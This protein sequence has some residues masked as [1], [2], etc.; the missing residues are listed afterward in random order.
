MGIDSEVRVNLPNTKAT[1]IRRDELEAS[2]DYLSV[3]YGMKQLMVDQRD[4]AHLA[5]V[6]RASPS[7]R[8]SLN[9]RQGQV[10]GK[11]GE[12][13]NG[14]CADLRAPGTAPFMRGSSHPLTGSKRK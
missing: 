13:A 11:I 1:P 4:R 5:N 12:T 6:A 9:I 2:R 10:S 8:S 7:V 3:I 14:A